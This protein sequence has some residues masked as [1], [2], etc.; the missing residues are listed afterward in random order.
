MDE[1][2]KID[3]FRDNNK[4]IKTLAKFKSIKNFTLYK[5]LIKN[6]VK[7]KIFKKS[8]FLILTIKLVFT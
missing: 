8:S 7:V 2:N 3:E 6:L 1:N 5:K 4:I